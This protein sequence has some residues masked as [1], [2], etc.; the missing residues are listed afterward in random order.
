MNDLASIDVRIEYANMAK[1]NKIRAWARKNGATV[2]VQRYARDAYEGS[3]KIHS[4]WN[5]GR[6]IVDGKAA[7]LR[8]LIRDL[9]AG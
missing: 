3:V 5:E 1:M 4:P 2:N 8:A 9:K 6:G 7:E